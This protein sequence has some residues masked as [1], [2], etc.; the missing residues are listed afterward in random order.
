VWLA[1]GQAA[2]RQEEDAA[3]RQSGDSAGG[4]HIGAE[5]GWVRGIEKTN[6][7]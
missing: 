3:V 4:V 1:A 2:D 5:D 6:F 7:L